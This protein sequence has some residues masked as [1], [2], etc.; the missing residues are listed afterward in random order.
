MALTAPTADLTG[1]TIAS[2][3]DQ[4]LILDNA[5]GIVENTLKIVSTQLGHSA[6]QIDDEKVLI[7]GV[8]T[9]NAL[10]FE[11]QEG[12]DATS[13]IAIG[14]GAT[15]KGVTI[16]ESGQ[17]DID[18]RVEGSSVPYALFVD[19]TN[20][21]VGIGTASPGGLL[22]VYGTGAPT[23][24]FRQITSGGGGMSIGADDN[25]ANPVWQFATNSSEDLEFKPGAT[26]ATLYLKNDGNV[27]I[28]TATPGYPLN[29]VSDQAGFVALIENTNSAATA[30]CLKLKLGHGTPTTG[31]YIRF[32]DAGDV[33]HGEIVGAG[34]SAVA[35][36][37][38]SDYRLKEDIVDMPS[39]LNMIN[40]L[41]PRTFKMKAGS[42][43]EYG[44][45]AHEL[46]E[47]LPMAVNGVNDA[48][49]DD[50]PEDDKMYGREK[51]QSI[52]KPYLV[53]ILTKAVQEL[54]AKVTA[55]ENA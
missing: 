27:G 23:T 3:Y 50:V 42:S 53:A 17:A 20:G 2:T 18:F 5:A 33:A 49:Y 37:E 26:A 35:Y 21:N 4:L 30:D 6:L 39:V 9:S 14:T 48:I 40:E 15:T 44:F 41:K 29:V 51:L 11:V 10:A 38:V 19:G 52:N 25:A 24:M 1:N 46:Q 22:E 16:N 55:L 47:V 32:V 31:D 45:V 43:T 12:A 8:D 7:K 34:G 28:G 54:S 13:Y 36:N